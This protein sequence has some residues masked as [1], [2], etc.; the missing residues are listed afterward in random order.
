LAIACLH[1][2]SLRHRAPI[3]VDD[4]ARIDPKLAAQ[5]RDMVKHVR[6][7]LQLEVPARDKVLEDAVRMLVRAAAAEEMQWAA[8]ERARATAGSAGAL[9]Q[10]AAAVDAVTEKPGGR[11]RIITDESVVATVASAFA[12]AFDEAVTSGETVNVIAAVS[13]LVA[14][15]TP[16]SRDKVV[17]SCGGDVAR[18]IRFAATKDERQRLEQMLGRAGRCATG[19]KAALQ[20]LTP[21]AAKRWAEASSK[22]AA[23]RAPQAQPA[24]AGTRRERD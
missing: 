18:R 20:K 22:W 13:T 11:G 4:A 17:P 14:L 5:A 24:E 2:A 7:V 10:A 6:T 21:D 12:A 23:A 9:G 19:L 1:L 8:E 15:T 3:D 16:L